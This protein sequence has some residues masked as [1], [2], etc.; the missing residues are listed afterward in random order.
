LPVRPCNSKL[1]ALSAETNETEIQMQVLFSE[2]DATAAH[3]EY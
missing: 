2:I 3:E 1:Q